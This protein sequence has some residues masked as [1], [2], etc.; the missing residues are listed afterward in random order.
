MLHY[1]KKNRQKVSDE[2]IRRTLF[3][4]W[5]Y[6]DGGTSLRWDPIQNRRYALRWSDPRDSIE[7]KYGN[8]VAANCLAFEALRLMPSMLIATKVRTTGFLENGNNRKFIWPIWTSIVNAEIVRSLLCLRSL[9][10]TPLDRSA[11]SAMGI[12]EVFGAGVLRFGKYHN[13][14]SAVPMF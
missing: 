9:H 4:C 2:A 7:K 6:G 13:F 12:Q 14:A 11:L 5:D 3:E 1:V 10:E 8:M